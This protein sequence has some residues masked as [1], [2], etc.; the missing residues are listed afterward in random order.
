MTPAARRVLLLALA[1][2]AGCLQSPGGRCD[3]NA[4]CGPGERCGEGVCVP[5]SSPGGGGSGG[6]VDPG[7]FQPVVWSTLHAPTAGAFSVD[8]VG[9]DPASGDVA[10]AGALSGTHAPWALAEGG[11]VASF[12]GGA[13]GA[14]RW[15]FPLP[16]FSPGTVR[17]AVA[18]GGDVLFAG[19]AFAPTTLGTATFTPAAG[20]ALL[21]GRLDGATGNPVWVRAIDGTSGSATIAPVAV[22]SRAGDLALA[23]TGAGDFGCGDTGAASFAAALAFADGSCLWSRGLGTKTVSHVAARDAGDVAVAGVCTPSGAFFDP[24]GGTTCARGLYLAVLSGATGA[25]TWA[26]TSSGAGTVVSVRDVAAAPGGGLAV[27]GDARGA[28]SFGGAAVDFGAADGSFAALFGATGTPG[29]VVRPVEAPT[30]PLPDAA[31]FGRCAYDRNGKL[32]LAGRY[33]GQPTVGGTRFSPCRPPACASASFLARIEADGRVGAFLPIR[34]AAAEGG[35]AYVDD[36]ALFAT[37]GTVAHA[38]RFTGSATIGATPW[39]TAAAGLG[40]LR[41]AP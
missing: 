27:V 10:V 28:V 3:V 25:T 41:I 6:G 36:L 9:A 12:A 4:D 2:S 23:G 22:A 14:V 13:P 15:L 34:A 19:T 16:T 29:L 7:S 31:A 17:T 5:V 32:W 37:T 38:L 33:F 21:V 18:P 20:G 39:S 26:K 35:G 1:A 11:Y 24:G 30:A 8:A 40:V